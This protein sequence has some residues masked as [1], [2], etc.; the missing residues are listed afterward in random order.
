MLNQAY[1][2]CRRRASRDQAC[3][4]ERALTGLVALQKERWAEVPKQLVSYCSV[5]VNE[6]VTC[7]S[8]FR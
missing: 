8:R 2:A 3:G 7:C 5:P 6:T 4:A 1:V